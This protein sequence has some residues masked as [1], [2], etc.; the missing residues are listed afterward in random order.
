MLW[1]IAVVLIILWLLG[2]VSSYMMGGIIHILTCDRRYDVPRQVN[3]GPMNILLSKGVKSIE[4]RQN[5]W[6]QGRGSAVEKSKHVIQRPRTLDE[7][8]HEREERGK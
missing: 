4:G 3:S 8:N 6:L 5:K 2:M 1:T 7:T